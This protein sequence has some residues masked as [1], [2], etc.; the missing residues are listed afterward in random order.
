MLKNDF[1]LKEISDRLL[2]ISIF[3]ELVCERNKKGY[4]VRLLPVSSVGNGFVTSKSDGG[5]EK[6]PGAIPRPFQVEVPV[7]CVIPDRLKQDIIANAKK[8][9]KIANQDISGTGIVHKFLKSILFAS[10]AIDIAVD[11]VV[12]T[13][14]T[15]ELGK[16]IANKFDDLVFSGIRKIVESNDKKLAELQ[17]AKESSLKEVKDETT[18]LKSA[19]ESFLYIEEKLTRDFP[20]SEML[21]P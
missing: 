4:P 17:E 11:L 15:D 10:P 3:E 20:D 21:V 1:D 9:E 12:S 19:V 7:S 18:A 8:E 14:V 2:E 5:M 13:Q 6:I 16:V